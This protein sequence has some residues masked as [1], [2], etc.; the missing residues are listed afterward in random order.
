MIPAANPCST[1]VVSLTCTARSWV[2]I[3]FIFSGIRT[4]AQDSVFIQPAEQPIVSI[5][6]YNKHVPAQ[7]YAFNKKKV[8]LIATANIAGYG[9]VMTGL[10]AA[11]YS[12]YPQSRFHTFNDI[13]EWKQ[14]DKV[15]H[16]FSAYAG[17]QASMEMWRWTGIDRKK[18]IWIGGLSGAAYLTVIE[19]LD[20]FSAEWGWSWG[21][22]GANMLGSGLLISQ[23]LAW[24]EQRIQMK[25][26]AHR[27]SYK[28][29]MLNARSNDL[30]GKSTAERILKDYNGQTYWFSTGVK[31]I[32]PNAGLPDW[33]QVSVGTGAE[34]MFG[35]SQNVGIDKT[36]SI[37]FDRRDI[38]RYRQWYLAPDIDLTKIKTKKKGVRMALNMLNLFK[39]PAPAL[40]YGHGKFRWKWIQF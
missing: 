20:G 21:D 13:G 23:E 15:G 12:Q 14:I 19:I 17:G 27:K 3:F 7:D 10:Y 26:S 5:N 29:P 32:L 9:A 38:K 18:R 39:F 2:I 36:G 16:M 28:D 25:F 11:W 40:E 8:R 31:R 6:S 35:A 33:L 37:E 22:F 30:F 4:H 24:D 34:G 1:F